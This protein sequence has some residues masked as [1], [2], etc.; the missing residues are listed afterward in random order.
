MNRSKIIGSTALASVMAASAAHAEMSISGLFAGTLADSDGGG[1]ASGFSTNSIYVNY[2]DSMDNGMGVAVAMSLADGGNITTGV[3]FDTGMGTIGL[4]EAQDSAMDKNDGSPACYSIILCGAAYSTYAATDTDTI[5][6]L[7]GYM[8]G[9]TSSGNSIAYTNTLGGISIHVTRGMEGTD[10]EPTMSYAASGS[11]MGATIKAGLSSIDFKDTSTVD[12]DPTFV[13]VAYSLAGLNLGYAV[14]DSD[15]GTE[16]TQMGVG[17]SMMGMDVGVT[18][19]ESDAATDVDFMRVSA[20][21]SLGAASFGVDF[22]E[23]DSELASNADD[24][25]AW[26]FTYVV[27][28]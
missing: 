22:T 27:G 21:K 1:L 18:I 2:S 7:T 11:I 17:T 12:R 25:D 6:N 3:S 9:D 13:T 10:Y 4:G 16:E 8:D 5:N 26:Q 28:F 20:S 15:N 19:A 14:Y 24:S 23:T